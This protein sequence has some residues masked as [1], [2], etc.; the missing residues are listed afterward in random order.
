M[1]IMKKF[2]VKTMVYAQVLFI[3][4]IFRSYDFNIQGEYNGKQL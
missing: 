3:Y 4:L 2:T 1:L